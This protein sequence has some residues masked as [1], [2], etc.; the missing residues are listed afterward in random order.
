MRDWWQKPL[1]CLTVHPILCAG[2]HFTQRLGAGVWAFRQPFLDQ[3]YSTFLGC[4]GHKRQRL[5]PW[6]RWEEKQDHW[7]RGA[8]YRRCSTPGGSA[9]LWET[10][11]DD[12]FLWTERKCS[13]R[14]ASNSH[15]E[16]LPYQTVGL[17]RGSTFPASQKDSYDGATPAS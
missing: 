4:A 6:N 14:F 2:A 12:D 11:S 10:S 1:F 8:N 16:G 13:V 9:V 17:P 5:I 3:L 15:S 7:E